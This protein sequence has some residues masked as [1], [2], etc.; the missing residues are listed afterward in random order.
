LAKGWTTKAYARDKYGTTISEWSPDACSWCMRG[1]LNAAQPGDVLGKEF[2]EITYGMRDHDKWDIVTV[3]EAEVERSAGTFT[4]I[5][6][7]E[8]ASSKED[9]LRVFDEAIERLSESPNDTWEPLSD[10]GFVEWIMTRINELPWDAKYATEHIAQCLD[11]PYP[12]KW[13]REIVEERLVS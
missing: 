6:N 2:K 8:Q 5:F 13:I 10:V 4:F 9:V 12:T 3:S 1:A 7:D 11:L